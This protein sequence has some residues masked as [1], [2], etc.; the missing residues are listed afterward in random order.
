MQ[1]ENYPC[2]YL[3]G[4][5][6][7]ERLAN[8]RAI[9]WRT[10][11]LPSKI[12]GLLRTHELIRIMPYLWSAKSAV[13]EWWQGLKWHWHHWK[14]AWVVDGMWG[15]G[16]N[17]D[18]LWLAGWGTLSWC[19]VFTLLPLMAFHLSLDGGL[20]TYHLLESCIG[21]TLQR[22]H[23][24][25]TQKTASSLEVEETGMEVGAKRKLQPGRQ[26]CPRWIKCLSLPLNTCYVPGF[27]LEL[28]DH[29]NYSWWSEW[30][31][32]YPSPFFS[33]EN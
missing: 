9:K 29:H 20:V 27:A 5:V 6:S 26:R 8:Y 13:T 17:R 33:W 12:I 32:Y 1:A 31:Y 19:F 24:A 18:L 15:V 30:H 2:Y 3:F 10:G 4:N 22:V 7:L 21:A 28:M 14:Q 16:E 25:R 11:N 23:G